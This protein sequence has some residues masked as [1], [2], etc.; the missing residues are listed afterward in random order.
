MISDHAPTSV[1]LDFPRP[2]Q[3]FS[4]RFHPSLILDE[5]FCK[6]ISGKITEYLETNNTSD[7]S[8]ATLWEAFKVVVRG[9]IIS[10]ES[11]I[12][13]LNKERL[14]EIDSELSQLEMSYRNSGNPQTLQ[15][16]CTLKYEYNT[17]LTKQ[18]SNQLF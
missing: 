12:K 5:A 3:H 11:S 18:V 13:K 14:L 2:K 8:D 7:V 4:W 17:I 6:F 9:H 16:I 10:Y 1:T 15:N